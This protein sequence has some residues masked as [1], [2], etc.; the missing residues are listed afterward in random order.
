MRESFENEVTQFV[1][2]YKSNDEYK[3]AEEVK[4]EP[5][6][7]QNGSNSESGRQGFSRGLI[8]EEQRMTSIEGRRRVPEINTDSPMLEKM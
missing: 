7:I 2:K 6:D 5:P 8:S 1:K 3:I 4:I